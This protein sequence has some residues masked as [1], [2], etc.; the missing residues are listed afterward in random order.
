M[1]TPFVDTDQIR[2][3][4]A[5]AM[6]AMYQAEVPQYG[7]LV[8][9]VEATN[10]ATLAAR[11][12]LRAALDAAG[13]LPRLS[14]ERH[15]AIR[16]GTAAE[17]NMLRRLFAVMGMHP[18]GYYDLSVAGVPVHSTGFR[19]IDA[20]SL[21]RN[22]FRLFTS[23]LRLDLI[24]S[25]RLREQAA[26]LLAARDIFTPTARQLIEQFEHDGGLDQDAA[27]RFVAA[28]IETFRW[29]SD[30]CVDSACYQALRAEHPL[31]ADIV[32]FRGPHINHLTPRTLDIDS[33]QAA[34]SD[35]AMTP[36]A[37]IEGPPP[38]NCPILLRQTSFKALDEPINF[39]DATAGQHS[40]RFG[41]IEQRGVALTP[42]GR[43]LYDSLIARAGRIS[44]TLGNAHYQQELAAIFVDFPDTH[45][46]LLQRNLAFYRYSV[47][48]PRVPA[49]IARDDIP[50]LVAA[51][52][53]RADPIL[54]EDFLPVSAAG[55]FHSNLGDTPGSPSAHPKNHAQRQQLAA[56]LGVPPLDEMA[57]YDQ[58]SHA[59]WQ[60]A[61]QQLHH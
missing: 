21:K 42:A 24:D 56:A 11:P 61:C 6:A 26:R 16:V 43:A 17:L 20:A 34:M 53:L 39:T 25:Q 33:A 22:P 31:V 40:A 2:A 4:F 41:E 8:S 15:G 13:E 48:Q 14:V 54:Y 36:K 50:A 27:Q 5:H 28:A 1:P 47:I 46:E 29:H 3:D 19:P 18:V 49:S 32:C 45:A 35:Y 55:I 23:L 58:T 59:S 52:C 7:K 37:I 57:L 38:R 10:A 44:K 30:A 60:L 12:P 9:L 51:G